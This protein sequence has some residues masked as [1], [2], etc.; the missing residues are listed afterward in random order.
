MTTTATE[1]LGKTGYRLKLSDGQP[2]LLISPDG[3][4]LGMGTF[5]TTEAAANILGVSQRWI[6]ELISRDAASP[7]TGLKASRYGRD[8]LI[9]V[10]DLMKVRNRPG[11]G[12]PRKS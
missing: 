9:I 2:H 10:G 12:R 3:V 6:Q 8:Y 5:I 1:V 7:G 11:P 4:S